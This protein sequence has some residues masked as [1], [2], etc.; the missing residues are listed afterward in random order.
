[1]AVGL[2]LLVIAGLHSSNSSTT[3]RSGATTQTARSSTSDQWFAAVCQ[4]GTFHNG[5]REVLPNAEAGASCMTSPR[6][7]PIFAGQY[8][9]LFV[10]RNDAAVFHMGSSAIIAT[11]SGG[12]ALFVAPTDRSGASLQ[13]LAQFGFTITPSN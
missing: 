1:M 10:A 8:S 6:G 12:Y 11:D 5:G 13:P 9:S 2:L 3:A 4:P 7:G